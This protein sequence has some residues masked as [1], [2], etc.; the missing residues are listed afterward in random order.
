MNQQHAEAAL[1]RAKQL[2]ENKQYRDAQALLVTI[3]HPTAEKWL[4][5]INSMSSTSQ[6]T[7]RVA[8]QKIDDEIASRQSQ[9]NAATIVFVGSLLLAPLGIGIV[10]LPFSLFNYFRHKNKLNVLKKK[11]IEILAAI[12]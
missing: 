12:P 5:R 11:R 4:A 10:L 9:K 3:D 8:L 7:S 2:I 6:Q 1:H